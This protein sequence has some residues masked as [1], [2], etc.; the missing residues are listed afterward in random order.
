[1]CGIADKNYPILA[2]RREAWDLINVD[3]ARCVNQKRPD[4]PLQN[5]LWPFGGQ[6]THKSPLLATIA[7][8]SEE[9]LRVS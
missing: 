5:I 6:N 3:D 9:T 1:M 4:R 7:C 8:F 2:P